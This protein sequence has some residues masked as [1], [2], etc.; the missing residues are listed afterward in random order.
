MATAFFTDK[1]LWHVFLLLKTL[2]GISKVYKYSMMELC[3]FFLIESHGLFN[4]Q[5]VGTVLCPQVSRKCHCSG[6]RLV[7][8]KIRCKACWKKNYLLSY[9]KRFKQILRQICLFMFPCFVLLTQYV[10]CRLWYCWII[11]NFYA[12]CL[13]FRWITLIV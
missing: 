5:S 1:F 6:W 11:L 7:R 3:D 2:H 4:A 8:K 10:A 13:L 12:L 9:W